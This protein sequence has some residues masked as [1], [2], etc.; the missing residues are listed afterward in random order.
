MLNIDISNLESQDLIN[1]IENN[2]EDFK[3][4]ELSILFKAD[5]SQSRV[6]RS[7]ILFLFEKN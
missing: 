7:L 4:F 2:I 3:N 6:I 1:F 5:Y